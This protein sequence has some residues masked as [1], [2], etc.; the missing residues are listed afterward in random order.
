MAKSWLKCHTGTKT[1]S[2]FPADRI[3]RVSESDACSILCGGQWTT[4]NETAAEIMAALEECGQIIHVIEVRG[5]DEYN[6]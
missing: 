1:I 4:V 3:D 5:G 6:H 2:Y